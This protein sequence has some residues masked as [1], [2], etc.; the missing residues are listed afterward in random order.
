MKKEAMQ[1]LDSNSR[2]QLQM[3]K[4]IEATDKL[5]ENHKTLTERIETLEQARRV[6]IKLNTSYKAKLSELEEY[7]KLPEATT[8][9]KESLWSKI[10]GLL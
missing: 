8:E 2:R 4:L 10:K 6:Q 5:E 3:A 9:E 7:I 1:R